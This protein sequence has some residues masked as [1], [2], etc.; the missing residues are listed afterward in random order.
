[1]HSAWEA[2]KKSMSVFSVLRDFPEVNLVQDLGAYCSGLHRKTE[3]PVISIIRFQ[4]VF[5]RYHIHK[6]QFDLNTT[7]GIP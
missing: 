7:T 4:T 5:F 6:A 1:M 3:M 2:S